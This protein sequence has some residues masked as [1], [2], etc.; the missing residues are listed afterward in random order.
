MKWALAAVVLGVALLH[1]DTWWW[2]SR[3]LVGGVLPVGLAYH[4]GFCL[5]ASLTMALLV[6]LAWPAH[7]ETGEPAPERGAAAGEARP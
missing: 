6:R 4:V 7:L 1:Q 3:D 2:K 5:V